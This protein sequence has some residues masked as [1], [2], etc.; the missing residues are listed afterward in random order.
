[1]SSPEVLFPGSWRGGDEPRL[2]A[3]RCPGCGQVSF[4][5]RELCP[6]CWSEPTTPL[7]LPARGTLYAFTIV[8]V[9]GPAADPPYTI[10]YADFEPG[11]RVLG[12]IVAGEPRPGATVRV[13]ETALPKRGGARLF[14]FAVE[15]DGG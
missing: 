5:P 8:H 3:S 10:G 7:D 4:P 13:T 6:A 15:A 9:A 14:A 1:M 11:V 2:L 12:Q